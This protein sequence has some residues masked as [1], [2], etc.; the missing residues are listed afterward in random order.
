M[1]PDEISKAGSLPYRQL[2]GSL[3]YLATHTRPDIAF[4]VG[5]L[6]TRNAGWS[7]HH[8]DLAKNVVRYLK[9][10]RDL[11]L[12]LGRVVPAIDLVGHADADYAEYKHNRRSVTGWVVSLYGGCVAWKSQRQPFVTHSSTEAE[13][14]ALD[15]LVR[16]IV[17]E[18]RV[19]EELGA[20][21]PTSPPTQ[22]FSDNYGATCLTKNHTSNDKFKHIDVKYHYI[23]EVAADRRIAVCHVPGSDNQAD[24]FTKALPKP[25]FV[26]H[27]TA[28]GLAVPRAEGE[29]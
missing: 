10:T 18:R 8:F 26:K 27:R 21:P 12:C 22:L 2:V 6:A 16:D 19:L 15:S 1:S 17:W 23:R 13:Y 3:Q 5:Q 24:I 9:G 29:C 11:G 14:V 4:A 25:L 28:L 7:E 20:L